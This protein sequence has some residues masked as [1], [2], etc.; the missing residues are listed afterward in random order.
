[1]YPPPMKWLDPMPEGIETL[2]GQFYGIGLG[3]KGMGKILAISME[4]D[5][6]CTPCVF[7][8]ANPEHHEAINTMLNV[9][10]TTDLDR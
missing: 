9:V 5:L 3:M 10:K 1:M 8:L 2:H 7:D 4:K 6:N